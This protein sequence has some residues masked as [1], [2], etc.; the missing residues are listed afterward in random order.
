M[1]FFSTAMVFAL[2]FL[3]AL[4]MTGCTVSQA[5]INTAVTDM[6]TWT[7]VVCSDAETLMTDVASFAASDAAQIEAAVKAMSTDCPALETAEQQYLAAPSASLLAQISSFVSTLATTDSQ[8][9]LAVLQIKDTTSRTV[10]QG[11]LTTIATAVTILS[12]F[13]ATAGA[14]Q[15][16]ATSQLRPYADRAVLHREFA[17]AQMQGLVPAGY[18]LAQSGF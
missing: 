7:P 17:R 10:A 4:P 18:S 16:V 9:L 15:T 8:A 2:C 1:K 12:G 13:L 5:K 11:V 3:L 14:S 6:Q